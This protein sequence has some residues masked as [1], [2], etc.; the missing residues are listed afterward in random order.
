M[1]E[2]FSQLAEAV[3]KLEQCCMEELGG[4]EKPSLRRRKRTLSWKSHHGD[5]L[6]AVP[7]P[8][9]SE[10]GSRNSRASGSISSQLSHFSDRGS[11]YNI[12]TALFIISIVLLAL[13]LLNMILFYRLWSLE[14]TARTFQ[15]WQSY[16]VSQGRFPQS[17]ADW[18]EI[19]ELQKRFHSTEVQKWKQ[20][21][22]ASVQL[23]DEMKMSLE[24]LQQGV[25]VTDPATD[26]REEDALS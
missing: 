17:S 12:P 16:A 1:E 2:H 4:R 14:H 26:P 21:L 19:L 11:A 9:E 7:P 6:S 10:R 23:L 18:A 3:V 22:R 15:T 20:T 24:R 8:L 25:L 5:A 13:V